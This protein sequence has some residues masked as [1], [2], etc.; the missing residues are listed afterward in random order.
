M[1][2][3]AWVLINDLSDDGCIVSKGDTT[4]TN[5]TYILRY[6]ASQTKFSCAYEGMNYIYST[7]TV[8]KGVWYFVCMTREWSGSSYTVKLYV[9]GQLETTGTDI[10]LPPSSSGKPVIIGANAWG[11][12][13]SIEGLIDD[14]R[15]Y[16]RTISDLEI[17]TIYNQHNYP[18]IHS[19]RQIYPNPNELQSV[20]DAWE[21]AYID[22]VQFPHGI[23]VTKLSISTRDTTVVTSV[24]FEDWD[25]LAG[26]TVNN[27]DTVSSAN[28]S[29][30][31]YEDTYIN[32][33]SNISKGHY[34]MADLDSVIHDS[35]S[36]RVYYLTNVED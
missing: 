1:S 35:L 36:V 4:F 16:N 8:S 20:L 11:L 2:V 21:I 23:T 18:E 13:D 31:T 34:V 6:H 9:N 26:T 12:S 5:R 14:V 24:A 15:I 28:D 30:Y 29:S 10:D 32:N 27:I 33:T 17:S 7:T 22:S 19:F 3:T 25:G